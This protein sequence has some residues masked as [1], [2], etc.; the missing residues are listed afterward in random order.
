MVNISRQQIL[1]IDLVPGHSCTAKILNSQVQ[2]DWFGIEHITQARSIKDLSET[3]Q[4][5]WEILELASGIAHLLGSN[6][7][8]KGHA[9]LLIFLLQLY[10]I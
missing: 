1:P 9:C 7:E 2:C 5:Y 8:A 10:I 6:P 3:C 4:S